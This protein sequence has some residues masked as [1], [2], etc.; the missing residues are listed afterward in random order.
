MIGHA[1]PFGK[2]GGAHEA[3]SLL[4]QKDGVS[5]KMVLDGSKEQTKGKFAKKCREAD[6]HVAD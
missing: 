4:F 5:P 3:C 2:R 1:P 6:Y